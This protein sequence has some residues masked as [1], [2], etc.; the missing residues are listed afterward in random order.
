MSSTGSSSI[1]QLR[2]G[3]VPGGP[4]LPNGGFK[5]LAVQA[6]PHSHSAVS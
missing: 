4:Q 2:C 5:Y 6:L 1:L 3:G